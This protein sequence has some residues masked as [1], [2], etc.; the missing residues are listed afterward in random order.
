MSVSE[1]Q[2]ICSPF[3]TAVKKIH[4]PII[5]PLNHY[6]VLH[7]KKS[8]LV[9]AEE[10]LTFDFVRCTSL[11]PQAHQWA[12]KVLSCILGGRHL[13]SWTELFFHVPGMYKIYPFFNGV[14]SAKETSY[15]CN[16]F[17]ISFKAFRLQLR[18]LQ[19]WLQPTLSSIYSTFA[20]LSLINFQWKWK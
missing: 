5:F 12:C 1:P 4:A 14:S 7:L 20:C 9:Q 17:F 2:V 3:Q 18:V 19:E 13:V 8:F 11:W 15:C 16:F 6:R 10:Y